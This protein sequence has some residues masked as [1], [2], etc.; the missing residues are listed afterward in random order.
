[1]KQPLTRIPDIVDVHR[2]GNENAEPTLLLEVPHGATRAAHFEKLHQELCGDYPAD[3]RDFFFVNTDVGSFELAG[4]VAQRWTAV[5]PSRA[6][7]VVRS[8]IPR[9]FIDCN[10]CIDVTPTTDSVTPGIHAYVTEPRD[11]SWLIQRHARY[12]DTATRAYEAVC[13]EAGGRAL[14]VHSY[15]PRSLQ[16]ETDEN[17]VQALHREYQPERI[18][19][20]PM[21]AEIDLISDT[22]EGERLADPTLTKRVEEIGTQ[23]GYEVALCRTYSLHAGTYARVFADAYPQKTLCVEVRRDLLVPEFTPFA[24]MVGDDDKIERAANVLVE[25]LGSN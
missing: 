17:V 14:M 8:L 25:A 10:R 16:I 6:A 11:R 4:R 7:L 22:P 13:G 1:M 12:I 23:N 20:W 3:L 15:A 2:H 19:H 21:R 18:E 9:T 24:E 5:D